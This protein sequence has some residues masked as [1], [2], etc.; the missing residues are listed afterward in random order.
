[1]WNLETRKEKIYVGSKQKIYDEVKMGMCFHN[2]WD[3]KETYIAYNKENKRIH[4]VLVK[5]A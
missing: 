3:N 4:G 2:M 1:L 5:S